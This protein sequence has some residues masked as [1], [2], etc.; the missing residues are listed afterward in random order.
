[1]SI[2]TRLKKYE[3]SNGKANVA[4]AGAGLM[5]CGM[6][7]QIDRTP[8]MHT[9]LIINRTIERAVDSYIYSGFRRDEII[10]SDDIAELRKA[11]EKGK[12]TVTSR[13]DVLRELERI[14]VLMDVTGAVEYGAQLA[15]HAF[16]GS[17]HVVTMNSETD[18]TVGC[19]L[20][21]LA[22]KAGLIYTNS[23]GDQPGVLQR[24]Y[25]FITAFSFEVTAIIN[26]KGFMDVNPTP[27]SVRPWAEKQNTSLPVT[28]AMADG[29]K[30]NVEQ[31]VIC[32]A[33]GFIPDKRGM[34]G[35]TTDLA[36]ALD[37]F[38]AVL[39]NKHVVDYTL[40]G[41]FK[42]GVFVIAHGNDPEAV[43]PYMEYLKMGSGPNYLFFRPYH[44][45]HY[46]TPLTI[47]EVMLEGEPLIAP[48]GAPIADVVTIAKK[49]LS[50]GEVLDGLGGYAIYGEIDIVKNARGLLPVGMTE[51]VTITKSIAKGEPIPIDAVELDDSSL[52]MRLRRDQEKLQ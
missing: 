47:A 15:L 36:H 1:M 6:V 45:C 52:L 51:G 33:M 26:C 20:N 32:N 31:A 43:Q 40:G 27:D 8:G 14:D 10:V 39:K 9:A 44:L 5:G 41:D 48:I 16:E 7:Y 37:D 24:L 3:E 17:K 22:K 42:G 49:D 30:M 35:I 50:A 34:H 23:D 25:D 28:T 38:V 29:T 12:P 4:V 19:A 2:Y 46:E 18:A 21:A 13:P 11:I